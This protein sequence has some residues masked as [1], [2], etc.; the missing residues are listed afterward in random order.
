MELLQYV[1][2]H[3][4]LPPNLPQEDDSSYDNCKAL[5]R[6]IRDALNAYT[7]LL[8][9][10]APDR[11]LWTSVTNMV[12]RL[13]DARNAKGV[14]SKEKM[15]QSLVAMV[16]GGKLK[17]ILM[18]HLAKYILI[19]SSLARRRSCTA[20]RK[21][22][23]G[24]DY[25]TSCEQVLLRILRALPNHRCGD[26]NKRPSMALLPWPGILPRLYLSLPSY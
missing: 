14:L 12:I 24:S 11:S 23:C 17:P 5:A 22:E 26:A 4:F 6:Q 20:H 13:L 15:G 2:D 18:F 19:H 7:A 10:Q 21:T 1:I 3:V 25:T 8:P 9:A 16:E